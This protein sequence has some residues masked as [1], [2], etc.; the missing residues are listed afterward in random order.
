MSFFFQFKNPTGNK[1]KK[2]KKDQKKKG[3]Q[4]IDNLFFYLSLVWH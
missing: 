2:K 3:H 1:Y 4:T